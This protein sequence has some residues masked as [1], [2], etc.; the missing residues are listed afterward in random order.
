MRSR[1]VLWG[2]RAGDVQVGSPADSALE[3][4]DTLTIVETGARFRLSPAQQRAMD[5]LFKRGGTVT[6]DLRG[7][8]LPAVRVGE[9]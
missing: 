5:R 8:E 7:R 1:L 3:F 2:A 4:F 9:R 6:L